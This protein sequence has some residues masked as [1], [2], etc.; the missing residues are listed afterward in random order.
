MSK[1][2]QIQSALLEL[3][4]GKFQKLCDAY[5]SLK[6]YDC[7]NSI[8]STPRMDK[9]RTGTP[10]TLISRPDGTYDFA[11]YTTKQTGLFNKL[12]QDLANC[13]DQS[14]TGIPISKIHE[15]ILCYTASLEAH[16]IENLTV[17]CLQNGCV[18]SLIGI[19]RLSYDLYNRYQGLARECLSIEVDTGQIMS[20]PE[21]VVAY[22]K[23]ALV[24]PLNTGFHFREAEIK[25]AVEALNT[26]DLIIFTGRPGCGKSRLALECCRQFIESNPDYKPYAI[27]NRGVD[28]FEDL[29]VYLSPD[30]PFLLLIDDA[31][32]LTGFQYALQ[33]LHA[34]AVNHRVKIVVTVRD[35]ALEDIRDQARQFGGGTEI[36]VSGFDRNQLVE[37]ISAEYG[38]N[39]YLYLKRITAI[40][41]GIPRLAIMAA[42]IA[43]REK[44]WKSISDVSTLYDEYF[45]SIKEDLD[46]ISTPG[47]LKVAGI[48]SFFRFVDR[49]NQQMMSLICQSFQID[50]E[51]FWEATT[52]LHEMEAFDLYENEVVKVTDQVLATYLFYQAAFKTKALDLTVLLSHFFPSHRQRLIDSLNSVLR[53][54]DTKGV[55]SVLSTHVN[56]AWDEAVEANDTQ[57]LYSLMDTFWFVKETDTLLFIKHA[58]EAMS[59]VTLGLAEISFERNSHV[60]GETLLHLLAHFRHSSLDNLPIAIELILDYAASRQDEVGQ[61]LYVL[62]E[63]FGIHYMSYTVGYVVERMVMEALWKRTREGADTIFARIFCLIAGR[64]LRI[65]I[66]T[67][68]AAEEDYAAINVYQFDVELTE[69]M[70]ELRQEIWQRLFILFRASP[71]LREDV[72]GT[73]QVYQQAAYEASTIGILHWDADILLSFFAS[74]LDPVLYSHCRI[75]QDYL[76][77]LS[78]RKI[79]KGDHLRQ[80][81][82]ND[83]YKLSEV[84][85]LD[86]HRMK[87][88]TYEEYQEDHR[89]H[90]ATFV[91]GYDRD[92]FAS[93][94]ANAEHIAAYSS[95]SRNLR[96]L[97]SSLITMLISL[98][99]TDP[100]LFVHVIRDYLRKGNQLSLGDARL[101]VCLRNTLGSEMAIALLR[102]HEYTGKDWWILRL[103]LN[104][105]EVEI[106]P[107]YLELLYTLYK[108]AEA[109]DIPHDWLRLM[110][111]R[112]LDPLI[113]LHITEILI[114]RTQRDSQHFRLHLDDLFQLLPIE[115]NG[116]S[117]AFTG[118]ISV[119]T[120][121]YLL[122]DNGISSVDYTGQAFEFLVAEDS[123]FLAAYIDNQFKWDRSNLAYEHNRDYG[124]LW[125]RQDYLS[126]VR[127]LVRQVM[128]HERQDYSHRYTLIRQFFYPCNEAND[129]DLIAERQARFLQRQ[130]VRQQGDKEYLEYL[131]GVISEMQPVKRYSFIQLLI[132]HNHDAKLFRRLVVEPGIPSWSGSKVPVLQD[133][134][135][136]YEGMLPMF[137]RVELLRHKQIVE[138]RIQG[139]REEIEYEKRS[140]FSERRRWG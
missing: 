105:P 97:H 110:K 79:R 124:F 19:D 101:I 95:R 131:F 114:G 128:K 22:G 108:T 64:L 81:F 25:Q 134:I 65:H 45:R 140:D 14:K 32:R 76:Q 104:L 100:V 12:N 68:E 13:F 37:L 29:K 58:I 48:V 54:F 119:L 84:V 112:C 103:L 34:D 53:D 24:T 126:L 4:G 82:T 85:R 139:L 63:R 77:L 80:K 5:L 42:Q 55:K 125:R 38:I 72:L 98:A 92:A 52:C 106:V 120:Q 21:F 46:G 130:I 107:D 39:D 67:T 122:A 88:Q 135:D 115:E 33:Y 31:N 93:M 27:Y 1:I 18:L 23:S 51:E 50:E 71:T 8:G 87:N 83:I 116:I 20:L 99:N 7:L 57:R 26:G 70:K 117:E 111:Y 40:A 56:T 127:R 16:E 91:S 10:D 113:I 11:E 6:G 136:F 89:R 118:N 59:P 66:R 102:E 47:V 96:E 73:L 123:R 35:Y 90:L 61:V 133:Q 75:V 3:D 30:V 137:N 94:F 69:Q 43:V 132:E 109:A 78:G 121:A 74:E 17:T 9:T 129:E 41:K 138:Q 49:A 60:E 2:N 36:E 62:S 86:L 28:L 15:V 44:T